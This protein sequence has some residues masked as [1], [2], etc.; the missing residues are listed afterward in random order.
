VTSGPPPGD[1]APTADAAPAAPGDAAP[2]PAGAVTWAID[3][4]QS[5]GGHRT[6]I[7]GAPAVIDTPAGKAVQ[8][9]GNDDALFVEH[10]PVSGLS[11][12]TAEVVMRPDPG[13]AQAQRYFH[14]QEEG[15][16]RVLFETR[17]FGNNFAA[18]V[19]VESKAGEYALYDAKKL[20]PLGAWY[21]IAVV[22][23]GKRARHFVNGVEESNVA[24]GWSAQGQG[25]TSIGVRI[26]RMYYF[27]GAIR[28]ARITPRALSPDE[29]L[30][31]N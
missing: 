17:L 11:Q 16:G 12:F 21:S 23:D 31:P 2:A 19:F 18:D 30:K 25:R 9:D 7:I 26:T 28:L 3:N 20:H 10:H 1:A 4:L 29:L 27:K 15:G 13:G 8:F 14:M 22:M 24:L 5:I 6:S